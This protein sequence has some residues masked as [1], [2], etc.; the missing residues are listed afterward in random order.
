M[1]ILVVCK[2]RYTGKDLVRDSYG[3]LH[4]IPRALAAGGD[5]VSVIATD[6]GTRAPESRMAERF[7]VRGVRPFAAR[8]AWLAEAARLRP[9]VVLASSDALHLAAGTRLARRIGVPVVL[10]LY[11]D[12]EAF[13]LSR[14][15]G[16]TGM[17][18][19]ACREADATIAVSSTLAEFLQ[20]RGPLRRPPV[21]VRN[22]VT[23]WPEWRVA[24]ADA[25][26]RLGL[27]ADGEIIGTVGALDSSR[28]ID[29]LFLAY[30]AVRQARP[31]VRLAVA[32]PGDA[33]RRRLLP[34]D[35][36][37]LGVLAHPEARLLVRAIDVG[38]ICNRDARFGRSCHPQKF[39]EM[40]AAGTP[41][42]TAAVGE[43]ARILAPWPDLLYAPGD[44]GELAARIV[45]QL[46]SPAPLPVALAARWADLA[47]EAR[48]VLASVVQARG[49]VT[50]DPP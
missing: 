44:P 13:G 21:V 25:R 39:V 40:V 6:Y 30:D 49:G 11:D 28:G 37:D 47:A 26:V 18:R 29:D 14:V 5:E 50:A 41:P 48:D 23:D 4:E 20:A 16:M 27:P 12:Y 34:A 17:L 3:R 8:G 22:G 46:A 1:R 33:R 7:R 45:R 38:V 42:V 15:P 9:D 32:G 35:A 19:R 10:D 24:R 36:I 31:G 43:V 2:R